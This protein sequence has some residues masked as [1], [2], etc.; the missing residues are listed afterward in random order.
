MDIACKAKGAEIT[1]QPVGE[2][3]SVRDL[4]FMALSWLEMD[5]PLQI[6]VPC[7]KEALIK[8]GIHG[9]DRHI[10]FRVVCQDMIRRLSLF[11]QWRNDLILFVKFPLGHVDP[12]SGIPEFFAI[13]LVSGPCVIRVFV[14]DGAVADLFGT[15]VADIRSPVKSY[16]ALFFEVDAGLIRRIRSSFLSPSPYA[17]M[18]VSRRFAAELETNAMTHIL[19]VEDDPTINNLICEYL[20]EKDFLCRQAFSGTEGRLLF[21]METFDLILL[22]L[23][24]PGLTGEELISHIRSSSQVPVIVLSAKTALEDKVSLLSTGADDYL[25]K[26]FELEELLAR[27]QVQLRHKAAG[28]SPASPSLQ[29]KDWELDE[30]ARAFLVK[31]QRLDLTAP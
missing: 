13:L 7:R 6:Y 1:I 31:G 17:I 11:D 15:A 19:I 12:G 24:I 8:I 5:L 22:D 29:Y 26:P 30:Q 21:D 18:A 23:M 14:G 2:Y 27:I 16:A 4:C 25:T 3:C 28:S 9:T 20:T 10:Q